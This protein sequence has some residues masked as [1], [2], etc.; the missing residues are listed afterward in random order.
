MTAPRRGRPRTTGI[1][2]AVRAAVH[3]LLAESGYQKSTVDMIAARAGVGK[4]AVYRR[5]RSKAELVFA[6]VVHN[7]HLPP[8]PETGS[9]RGDVAG[10][11]GVIQ[12]S[13]DGPAAAS[14]IPG[15]LADVRADPEL[16]ERFGTQFVGRQREYLVRMVDRAV[17]RGELANRPD[18]VA[19]HAILLGSVFAW[20]HMLRE[21]VPAGFADRLAG[22][23]TAAL[24]ELA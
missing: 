12:S 3:E 15:L 14:A 2:D 11:L 22:P 10:V 9:L 6:A 18:P 17:E 13:L 24:R 20:L 1:D 16:A 23:L 21:P 7:E 5:W 4:A 8:P 19:V